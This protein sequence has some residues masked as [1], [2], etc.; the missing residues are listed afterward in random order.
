[1]LLHRLSA[2]LKEIGVDNWE[3]GLAADDLD[4]DNSEITS[5]PIGETTSTSIGVV[6]RPPRV[7]WNPDVPLVA[8]AADGRSP[9][10]FIGSAIDNKARAWIVGNLNGL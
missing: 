4:A 9:R 6:S 5:V 2:D 3:D 10:L 7:S 1:M 8:S